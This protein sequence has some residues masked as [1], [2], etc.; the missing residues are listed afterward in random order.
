MVPGK[1]ENWIFIMD[2]KALGL[3]AFPFKALSTAISTM[4]VNFC[5]RLEKQYI[6]NPSGSLNFSWSVIKK[7]SDADTIA[8][9][10]FLKVTEY[11]KMLEK[12]P[13]NQLEI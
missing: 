2:T 11:H 12:I 8:K 9:I 5:G 3:S 10:Q 1:V 4:Q 13:K 6:L 7:F